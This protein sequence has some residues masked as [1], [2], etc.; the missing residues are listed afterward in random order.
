[1]G[2]GHVFT[3]SHRASQP[4]L[5]A[6]ATTSSQRGADRSSA[7][8]ARCH[9]ACTRCSR[10][11]E[12]FSSERLLITLGFGFL[13]DPGARSGVRQPWLALI[14]K[15]R[16]LQWRKFYF[17]RVFG[18]RFRRPRGERVRFSTSSRITTEAGMADRFSSKSSRVFLT[19]SLS[20]QKRSQAV[21]AS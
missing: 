5:I 9:R 2:Y 18:R 1:M 4:L 10:G 8:A 19:P 21:H 13:G 6:W 15:R 20:I 14:R 17:P 3:L 11:S 12:G 16:D 7:P